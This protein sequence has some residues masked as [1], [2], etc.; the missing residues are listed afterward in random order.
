MDLDAF[1]CAVEELRDP[2]LKNKP[3]AVGGEADK[4][5]VI[6]SCSYAARKYGVHSAMAT[7]RAKQLCPELILI[8]GKHNEYSQ[9]SS[10]VMEILSGHTALIEKVSIDEAFMDVSDLPDSGYEI[11]K[12]LQSEIKL[13]THLSASFGVATN[14]LMAK[15]ANDYG[16]KQH[17]GISYPGAIQQV[18]AGSE[19]DF[20]SGLP[21]KM[22]WGV[23]EKTEK[24]LSNHGIH[25]IGEL[26]RVPKPELQKMFGKNG[27]ILHLH[28]NGIDESELSLEHD[29]KSISQEVTFARDVGD[30]EKIKTI[31]LEMAE[32][33]G[34]RL[35]EQKLL[36]H[37]IKIKYRYPD[38][39]TFTRQ[40]TLSTPTNQ[41]RKI[42]EAGWE[43]LL[44]HW[45]RKIP[46]RL[47]GL[48]TAKFSE[49]IR[50]LSLWE[51]QDD[52]EAKILD[53]MDNLSE[54]YGKKV[55][56]KG[57]T[58]RKN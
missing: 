46:L 30:I 41:D 1:F 57:L 29:V 28:A 37:T 10:E 11:A 18:P 6:A 23:G 4:R 44:T 38:F 26:A 15:I 36:A 54:K 47:I 24:K 53:L 14:K 22:L 32:V 31:L 20:L 27:L 3:F 48:G 45:N 2:S 42:F 52:K 35:R 49:N 13:K 34:Y 39:S 25:L 33:L 55:I 40:K 5:G 50:Q 8:R 9:K 7:S 43:L 19:A 17:K 51:T 16:K 58:T 21:V 56:Q 12:K